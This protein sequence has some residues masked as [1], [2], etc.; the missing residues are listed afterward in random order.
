MYDFAVWLSSVAS[1]K[2]SWIG[3]LHYRRHTPCAYDN[4]THHF[5]PCRTAAFHI[6]SHRASL[7]HLAR[8][9]FPLAGSLIRPPS[10]IIRH[11]SRGYR[12]PTSTP[13]R[14]TFFAQSVGPLKSISNQARAPAEGVEKKK[15]KSVVWTYLGTTIS[16]DSIWRF[17]NGCYGK[18]L[19]IS[20]KN[21][22]VFCEIC[23]VCSDVWKN[24]NM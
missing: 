4:F 5:P 19:R 23:S 13:G 11:I 6:D 9:G 17:F 16:S 14:W 22:F 24:W 18:M 1:D 2:F 20:Q 8:L 12:L 3:C 21:M 7:D 15:C 10:T